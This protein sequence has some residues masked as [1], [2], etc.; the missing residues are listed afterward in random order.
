MNPSVSTPM[1]NAK[2]FLRENPTESRALAAKIFN[3]NVKTLT[4]SIQ[5]GSD[6]KNEEHNKVLQG[7]EKKCS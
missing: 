2:K 7:H 1:K 4:A 3:E 5:R 6:E